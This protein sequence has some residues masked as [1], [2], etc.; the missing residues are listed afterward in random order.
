MSDAAQPATEPAAPAAPDLSDAALNAAAEAVLAAAPA[1]AP[2]PAVAQPG[3]P[4]PAEQ[5]TISDPAAGAP[6]PTSTTPAPGPDPGAD[7]LQARME[8]MFA[9][10]AEQRRAAEERAAADRAKDAELAELRAFRAKVQ[11][12]PL[13]ALP[14]VGWGVEE[15][16]KAAISGRTPEA[17]RIAKLEQ[18][19]AAERTERQR[20]EEERRLNDQRAAAARE[21]QDYVQQVIPRALGDRGKVKL[22]DAFADGA[23]GANVM[24]FNLMRGCAQRGEP[25]PTASEA[26]ERLEAALVARAKR[27]GLLGENGPQA[28][29]AAAPT[30]KPAPKPAVTNAVTPS[31]QPLPP[32]ASLSDE[33]LNRAAAQFLAEHP[34][35]V[36]V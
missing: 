16:N 5:P 6:A 3:Q 21:E 22:L 12:R 8:A 28:N 13:E 14:E 7:P 34:L 32:P 36:Q 19:L 29:Q 26:A 20:S 11:E 30:A 23:E 24:V 2:D 4:P 25:I 17:V 35:M 10:E 18:A 9:K 15:L 33:D 31:T 1:V 27:A